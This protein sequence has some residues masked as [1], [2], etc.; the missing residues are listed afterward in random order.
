MKYIEELT[1][2]DC[3]LYENSVYLLTSDFKKDGSRLCYRIDMGFPKWFEPTVVVEN[4]E[5]Y[6]MDQHNN[7]IPIRETKKNDQTILQNQNIL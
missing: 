7:I 1:N 4:T 3:F 6:R 2:G 5:I